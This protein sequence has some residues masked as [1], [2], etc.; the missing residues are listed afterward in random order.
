MEL[1]ILR[2]IKFSSCRQPFRR[3]APPPEADGDREKWSP[4]LLLSQAL[5]LV[6]LKK[7]EMK[8]MFGR[9]KKT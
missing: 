8:E 6:S 3:L 1:E 5:I 9:E 4:S 7:K 2:L